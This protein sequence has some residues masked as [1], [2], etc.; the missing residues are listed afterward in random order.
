[1]YQ[2]QIKRVWKTG[3][4]SAQMKTYQ[5]GNRS[6]SEKIDKSQTERNEFIYGQISCNLKQW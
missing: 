6:I 2:S 1:M 3:M 5:K 4:H